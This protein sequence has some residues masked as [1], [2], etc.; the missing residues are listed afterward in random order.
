MIELRLTTRLIKHW[1][2]V[3]KENPLPTMQSFNPQAVDDLWGRCFKVSVQ[4]EGGKVNY[5]YEMIG[6]DLREVFGSNLVGK[7]VSAQ[8]HFLPA[9]KIIE[10]MD[11]A[12]G[13]PIPKIMDGQFIDQNN[14]LIKYR[15]CL[16]PFGRDKDNVTN[17]VIGISWNSFK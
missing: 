9:K 11:E 5:I 13:N 10:Q 2:M 3:K 12:L 7:K 4:K 8:L 6:D 1:E 14:R 17:F 16:L 15:S